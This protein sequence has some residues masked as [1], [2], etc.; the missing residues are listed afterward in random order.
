MTGLAMDLFPWFSV[1]SRPE[2]LESFV[3][4]MYNVDVICLGVPAN[5]VYYLFFNIGNSLVLAQ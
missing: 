4:R 2:G 3:M 1:C 5:Q